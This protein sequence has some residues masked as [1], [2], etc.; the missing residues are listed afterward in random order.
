MKKLSITVL[1]FSIAFA[2]FIMG[3]PLLGIEFG[4][5]PLMQIADVLDLFT[6]L[7]LLPLY[8]LLFR[9]DGKPAT[10]S[11]N[12]LFM[13]FIAFWALGQGMHL[14][15][16]SIG[17]IMEGM[18]SA[19]VFK[20]T[21]FYDETLSHYLWHFGVISLSGLVIYRQWRN[22]ITTEKPAKVFLVLAG[23][24]Y[25]FTFFA[26]VIEGATVPMSQ[27]LGILLLV[28]TFILGRKRFNEEP[29]IFMFFI[30][31]LIATILFAVWGIWQ[32]GFPEFTEVGII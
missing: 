15:A 8:W 21:H 31:Y 14:S 28:V 19:D 26:M 12:L 23:I 18:E 10:I 30:A 22:P 17:N 25:G 2:I 3:P 20:L 7:V 5:Y 4:P 24:F 16:N 32:G 13:I 1:V 27:P 6:P 9:L 29:I 11:E